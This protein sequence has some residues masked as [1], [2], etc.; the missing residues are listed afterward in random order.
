MS[1]PCDWLSRQT[2]EQLVADHPVADDDDFHDGIAL[3]LQ[4]CC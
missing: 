3:S 1:R 4:C 2:L